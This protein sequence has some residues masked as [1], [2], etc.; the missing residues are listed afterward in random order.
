MIGGVICGLLVIAGERGQL[1]ASAKALEY[2]GIVAVGAISVVAA[3]MIS[4]PFPG[5]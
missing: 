2:G 3:I 4:E 1:G 5:L